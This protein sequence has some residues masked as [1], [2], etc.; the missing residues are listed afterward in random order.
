MEDLQRWQRLKAGDQTALEEIYRTH[1]DV[2]YRYGCKFSNDE[3]LVKDAIQDLFIELWRNHSGLGE[4]N[5]IKKYLLA[6]IRR[7]IVKQIEKKKKWFLPDRMENSV[8]E[9]E[10]SIEE[11]LI[12]TE[13]SKENA[14]LVKVAFDGLSKRQKEA[15]YLKYYMDMDYEEIEEI[16]DINYQSLRN[17]VSRALQNMRAQIGSLMLLFFLKN[18]ID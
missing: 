13:I 17:L 15:I 18:F 2:L 11:V 16:M 9:L 3:A 14:D 7:K 6:S 5:S 1:V 10:V 8:F 4:T 12:S